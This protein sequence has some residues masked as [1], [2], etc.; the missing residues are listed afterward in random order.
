MTAIPSSV[1]NDP[2]AIL[3]ETIKAFELATGKVLYSGQAE[4]LH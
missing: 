1:D 4:Y 3:Q 2:S